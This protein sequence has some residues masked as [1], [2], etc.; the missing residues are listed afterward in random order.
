LLEIQLQQLWNDKRLPF[1]HFRLNN[2]Q[3]IEII[4]SGE[5]NISGSG[6]DFQFAQVRYDQL[7]WFGS[8]E[9]HLKSSDWYRHQHHLDLAYENV[10]LH[11][12]LEHDQEVYVRDQLLPTLELKKYL[13]GE[14]KIPRHYQ[15]KKSPSLNCRSHLRSL[16]TELQ[17]M[18]HLALSSRL[19][20]KYQ[21]AL[22]RSSQSL[23]VYK[24][25]SKAFG[26]K[27]NSASFE[28]LASQISVEAHLNLDPTEIMDLVQTNQQG[29]KGR[30]LM[31][32]KQLMSRIQSWSIF[33]RWFLEKQ[34]IDSSFMNIEDGF[35]LANIKSP[36][37]QKNLLI[38]VKTYVLM[39][40]QRVIKKGSSGILKSMQF[41]ATIPP[42][43]N[44][45]TKLW[46]SAGVSGRNALETQANL[47]IYQ[48]FCRNNKCMN[49]CVGQQ[50][51][52]T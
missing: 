19:E 52:N 47:E 45:L 14:F 42:E 18:Q 51:L 7:T 16:Q 20:R 44:H 37:L 5:W 29:W 2:D 39:A 23:D 35:D 50:L 13:K 1:H 31:L 43:K 6:P 48:Q 46:K 10:I 33:V 40:N 49:C 32:T 21:E 22:N 15:W 36:L 11:V 41:L 4:R 17:K 3:P 8:I 9:F 12:V 34:S 26:T 25:I 27:T 30:N 24:L 28:I 38:N